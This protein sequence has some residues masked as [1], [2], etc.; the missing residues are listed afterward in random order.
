M[1]YSGLPKENKIDY[2][3]TSLST[4]LSKRK[5]FKFSNIKNKA[6]LLS[7]ENK[8]YSIIKEEINENQDF[9][10]NPFDSI[11]TDNNNGLISKSKILLS[12]SKMFV[13]GLIDSSTVSKSRSKFNN[14]GYM[15][16]INQ[17]DI[18]FEIIENSQEI[19]SKCEDLPDNSEGSSYSI[20]IDVDKILEIDKEQYEDEIIQ[21]NNEISSYKKNILL[22]S[23]MNNE[24]YSDYSYDEIKSIK[25]DTFKED[26]RELI[27][28]LFYSTIQIEKFETMN[29][30]LHNAEIIYNL[31]KGISQIIKGNR[32][33]FADIDRALA[34]RLIENEILFEENNIISLTILFDAVNKAK[35]EMNIAML[36]I[37]QQH[38]E[39]G[40]REK[41]YR[42][43]VIGAC[44]DG[45]LLN[46]ICE[47]INEKMNNKKTNEKNDLFL[48]ICL[49]SKF[50]EL[51]IIF[52]FGKNKQYTF[53]YNP[54]KKPIVF[55]YSDFAVYALYSEEQI[56]VISSSLGAYAFQDDS[57]LIISSFSPEVT[58]NKCSTNCD[59]ISLS[60]SNISTKKICEN[61]LVSAIK[62]TIA[63]RINSIEKNNFYPKS[64]Y[65]LPIKIQNYFY[66]YDE[67]L[68]SLFKQN[69]TFS[70]DFRLKFKDLINCSI[71]SQV[72]A[73]F[74][75]LS[76]G[77]LYCHSCLLK[78]IETKTNLRYIL[79]K[80][81]K[82]TAKIECGKCGEIINDDSYKKN[83]SLCKSQEE[84]KNYEKSAYERLMKSFE[85]HC[86]VCGK[87]G[88]TNKLKVSGGGIQ[89]DH[90]ICDLCKVS[91][92]F[93]SKKN[94]ADFDCM[95]CDT[96][97]QY[98]PLMLNLDNVYKEMKVKEHIISNSKKKNRKKCCVIF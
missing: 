65:F 77:C 89:R 64:S 51:N 63:Y 83:I 18:K 31:K 84:I 81:E 20:D 82:K 74:P 35:N 29:K 55:E 42:V 17:S 6:N 12:R 73:D 54:V 43:F 32:R 97:H 56:N 41:A 76:C 90:R 94:E 57:Q 50:F 70:R 16:A 5:D 58:C 15:N 71:C 11:A 13:N 93:K 25:T 28:E 46:L 62:Q 67:D 33:R 23:F 47:V 85:T 34:F 80:F 2:Q 95:F 69:F 86:A 75:I 8:R 66:L 91:L 48:K 68:S 9:I 44:N 10:K 49:F 53:D 19:Q 52:S 78:L 24:L 3:P 39:T 60:K 92:D 26:K 27:D 72:K 59:L 88:T 61:C 98:N 14:I 87:E 96:K 4:S 40:Q 1:S 45:C 79:N 30:I 38:L 7:S 21:E 22:L 37:I 36:K